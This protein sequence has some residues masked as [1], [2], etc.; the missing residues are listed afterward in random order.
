MTLVEKVGFEAK[1]L[2]YLNWYGLKVFYMAGLEGNGIMISFNFV[3][4]LVLFYSLF[5]LSSSYSGKQVD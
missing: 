4:G 5:R 2:N 1:F 3:V